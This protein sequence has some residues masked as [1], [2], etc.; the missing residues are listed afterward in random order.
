M[1]RVPEITEDGG[2]AILKRVFDKERQLQG[3]LLNP[4]KVMAHCPEVLEATKKFYASFAASG[5]VPA[6]LQALVHV[7]V[8][9]INGCPF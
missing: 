9:S 7:R 4:T 8:A 6:A 2:N 3:D 5:R 1:P